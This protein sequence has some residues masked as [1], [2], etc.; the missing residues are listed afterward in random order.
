MEQ[1]LMKLR[2]IT[3]VLEIDYTSH[4]SNYFHHRISPRDFS[5]QLKTTPVATFS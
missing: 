1:S 3:H 2:A 5:L 4:A